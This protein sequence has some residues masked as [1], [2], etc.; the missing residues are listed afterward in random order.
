MAKI[1]GVRFRNFGKVYYFDPK[2]IE[3]RKGDGVIVE[4]SRGVEYGYVSIA[5]KEVGDEE[6]VQPLKPVIRKATE[7]DIEI[8]RKNLE[9]TPEA[10]KTAEELIA[11]HKLKM[12]LI[13]AEFTFDGTKVVFYFTA[14][15]RIDF[16]DLVKDLASA[17]HI[18][19]ELRQV[20]IRDE[21]KILGGIAPCGRE[22]C[23]KGCVPDFKKVTIKMAKMQGLSLN[24]GKIS[25]LC[26]RLMCCLEYENDYYAGVYKKMP[27]V[28]GTVKTPEGTGAVVSNNMLSLVVKVKI[29]K[30][31]GGTVYKDFPLDEVKF[32][33]CCRADEDEKLSPEEQAELNKLEE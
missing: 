7:K 29:D 31:D 22:V 27:K 28:G 18:R 4:T 12:K 2:N 5:N 10:K 25:G 11:K 26:G 33:K 23:C 17:F 16:R 14:P 30:P 24:P 6:I 13:D 3:F 19:I 9:K 20:G 15:T 21:A 32:N 8:N 1:V